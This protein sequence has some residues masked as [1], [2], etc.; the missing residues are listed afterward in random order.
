MTNLHSS[1]ITPTLPS[2]ALLPEGGRI[3]RPLIGARNTIGPYSNS[4]HIYSQNGDVEI[5]LSRHPNGSVIEFFPERIGTWH[6]YER[7]K[8]TAG[9]EWKRNVRYV[10]SDTGLGDLV[11]VQP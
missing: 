8:D 4:I 2:I 3:L 7:R 6:G 1:P 9:S 11:E 5:F 10:T